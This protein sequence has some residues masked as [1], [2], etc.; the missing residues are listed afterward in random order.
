LKDIYELFINDKIY[1]QGSDI[2]LLYLSMHYLIKRRFVIGINLINKLC[3]SLD[4]R[5]KA[6]SYGLLALCYLHGWFFNRDI[7]KAR[8]LYNKSIDHCNLNSY[9]NLAW[10]YIFVSKQYQDYNKALEILK[11]GLKYYLDCYVLIAHLYE[12]NKGVSKDYNKVLE[13]TQLGVKHNNSKAIRNLGRLYEK[14]IGV[15]TDINKA[16]HYY[17]MATKLNN[18]DAIFNLAEIY[19]SQGNYQ[20]A[21]PLYE[22]CTKYNNSKAFN[23]LG[24]F[25][26][27]GF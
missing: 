8:E 19:K 2:K 7:I 4:S 24:I 9:Y 11:E 27:L 20:K 6:I 1:E 22:T 12:H 25:Y 21:I 14:G 18:T 16:I 13:Y 5:I 17:N 10:S 15:D 26:A 23:S 3:N